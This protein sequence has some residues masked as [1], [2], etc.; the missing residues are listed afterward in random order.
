LP[1]D[2]LRLAGYYKSVGGVGYVEDHQNPVEFLQSKETGVGKYG[3]ATQV[4][5]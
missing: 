4:A 3:V 2:I 5:I 1:E